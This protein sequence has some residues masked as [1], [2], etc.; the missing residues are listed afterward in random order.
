[1]TNRKKNIKLKGMHAK[2]KWENTLG[3]TLFPL[4]CMCCAGLFWGFFF[5]SPSSTSATDSLP[6][7]SVCTQC[8]T[9][10]WCF[11][12]WSAKATRVSG[13]FPSQSWNK[14]E[15]HNPD[16]NGRTF[17]KIEKKTKKNNCGA[18]TEFKTASYFSPKLYSAHPG[19]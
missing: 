19:L 14:R 2:K 5:W 13:L 17:L 16:E 10:V 18:L 8:L 1:M 3:F 4:V 6:C 7:N 15:K 11:Q 12:L 9:L